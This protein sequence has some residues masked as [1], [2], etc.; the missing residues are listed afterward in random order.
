MGLICMGNINTPEKSIMKI[1]NLGAVTDFVHEHD[2]GYTKSRFLVHVPK[3]CTQNRTFLYMSF[4]NL[5]TSK[6]QKPSDL[7]KLEQNP[8]LDLEPIS[9]T[10]SHEFNLERQAITTRTQSSTSSGWGWHGFETWVQTN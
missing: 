4:Q 8:K 1:S 2:N 5:N 9:A 7:F 6:S 3:T 10:L